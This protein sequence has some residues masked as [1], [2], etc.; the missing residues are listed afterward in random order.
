VIAIADIGIGNRRSVEK[1]FAKVGADARLT[2]DL[3][4]LSAAE[5]L[6]VMGV[7][8]FAAAMDAMR[9]RGVDEVVRARAEAGVPVIGLCLGMQLLFERSEELGG[10]DG[11]GLLEGDVRVLDVPGLKVP[12]IGWNRVTFTRRSQLLEGLGD[13]EAFYHVH[14]LTAR[15]ADEDLVLGWGDYGGRFAS[16]VQRDNVMGCQFHPE[17][18]S[19]AGL[20]LLRNFAALCERSEVRA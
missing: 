18:S 4:A 17:K 8:A 11:L 2:A 12:H 9:E 13:G 20:A 15:P 1:A 3:G 14:S 10:D 19:T 6:V 5:G 16:I 7:G